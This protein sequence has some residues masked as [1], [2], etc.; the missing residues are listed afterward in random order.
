VGCLVAW[1]AGRIPGCE[2]ELVDTDP[3]KRAVAERLGVGF[4]APETARTE[5]DRV[6]HCS[7]APEGLATALRLAGLEASVVEMSWFGDRAVPLPLGEAFH[8]RR[9]RL[10]SSQVG[11]VARCQRPR[12]SPRRRMALALSLLADPTLECL[13]DAEHP[14]AE[15][16]AVMARLAREPSGALCHRI[17]YPP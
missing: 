17:R 12:W 7:G 11:E 8:S 10:R 1:L 9:L 13:I 3:G 15:L 4:A 5:A 16:P 14:F 6:V 2:V